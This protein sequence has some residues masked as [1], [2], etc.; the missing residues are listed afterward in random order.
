[1][2]AELPARPPSFSWCV[3]L[4]LR[5]VPTLPSFGSSSSSSFRERE[6]ELTSEAM[7]RM[8]EAIPGWRVNPTFMAAGFLTEMPQASTWQHFWAGKVK[9]LIL[10]SSHSGACSTMQPCC[11]TCIV[12]WGWY[13]KP[14]RLLSF[15]QQL[16]VPSE[17]PGEF[18]PG[19]IHSCQSQLKY[20]PVVS[21]GILT[22]SLPTCLFN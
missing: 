2:A 1:M 8:R 18:E 21:P 12:E 10:C 20:T 16:M 3:D 17:V 9:T 5:L 13:G 19:T 7:Q 22:L 15:D 14:C 6:P 4:A 11:V